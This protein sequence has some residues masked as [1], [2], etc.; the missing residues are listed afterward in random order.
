MLLCLRI[1]WI[2]NDRLTNRVS[3]LIKWAI[4]Y[5]LKITHRRTSDILN[6]QEDI[7]TPFIKEPLFIDT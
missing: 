3:I 4:Q 2:N 1:I 7:Q 5:Q 6:I